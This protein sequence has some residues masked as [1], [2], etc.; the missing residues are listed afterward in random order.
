MI[1]RARIPGT[2]PSD[3]FIE[4]SDRT[5]TR[6][7]TDHFPTDSNM[8]RK[9]IF[10]LYWLLLS[11][12]T[13][14]AVVVLWQQDLFHQLFE[15]DVSRLSSIILLVFLLASGHAGF[16]LFRFSSDLE[17]IRVQERRL[18][19]LP[20]GDRFSVISAGDGLS[21]RQRKQLSSI[22][23]RCYGSKTAGLS[24]NSSL[25]HMLDNQ[26]KAPVRLGWL[27]SDLLI[28]LGLLGTVIGF[29]LMLGAISGGGSVDISNIDTLLTNMGSG[30]RVALFT[31][32]TGLT[33]GTLLGFQY[34]IVERSADLLMTNIAEFVE[35]RIADA[36][37]PAG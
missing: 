10:P 19:A 1:F 36:H 27:L 3:D 33:T 5:H 21:T 24:E 22:V 4:Q 8:H 2:R 23:L 16:Y 14:I 29:I 30:M 6:K 31:T 20:A 18:S 25:I 35:L 37:H 9:H 17:A 13:A 7:G 15:S 26:I 32:L 11:A 28:K 12:G 34:F